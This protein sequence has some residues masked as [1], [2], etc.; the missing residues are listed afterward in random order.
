MDSDCRCTRS[1]LVR[2]SFTGQGR[3]GHVDRSCYSST[4]RGWRIGHGRLRE[5]D[6]IAA[7]VGRIKGRTQALV[8]WGYTLAMKHTDV[9]TTHDI[10]TQSDEHVMPSCL[11]GQL[12]SPNIID[13]STNDRF[14]GGIDAKLDLALR[15][16]R[17][18][19]DAKNSR[20]ASPR[21]LSG[22]QGDDG[23]TYRVEAG[24]IPVLKPRANIKEIAPGELA[25]DVH[26]SD[27]SDLR[28]ML[29]K[30]ARKAG[31]NPDEV[32]R[33]ALGIAS[34]TVTAAPT[35][36]MSVS[37]WQDE[38]YRATAKIAC[39]LLA[40][41]SSKLF[42]HGNF[43]GIRRYVLDGIMVQ[44][45]PV[46]GTRMD[47]RANGL[48]PL[49][50]LVKVASVPSGEVL[51]LVVYSGVLAF[52]VRLGHLPTSFPDVCL[53]YRVDQLGQVTRSNAD[54][55]MQ[56][57]IPSFARAVAQTQEEL[58][59]LA[60]DQLATLGPEVEKIQRHLWLE[61]ILRPL[62][63]QFF[64]DLDGREPTEEE[65]VRFYGAIA[66][67]VVQEIAPSIAKRRR[68]ALSSRDGEHE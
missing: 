58:L 47:I 8:A 66:M 53:S 14:G 54:E 48:G 36:G 59:Q 35:V 20:G 64:R 5:F 43:T 41:F 12:V 34:R 32:V 63:D 55:D 30:K 42:L 18:L 45:E 4:K 26:V 67:K 2:V 57:E 7:V 68:D 10:V 6:L 56:L 24:G 23:R 50:H 27:E 51:G 38:P 21:A 16:F 19:L 29:T 9:Y 40:H 28:K 22:L 61:R 1:D 46:Q 31:K 15:S 11:G 62:F 25:L 39:N 37:L 13:K 49:D 17:I 52:V 65:R 33:K 3:K 60:V 44:P